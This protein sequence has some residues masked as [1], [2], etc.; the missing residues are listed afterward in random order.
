ME[1]RFFFFFF[2]FQVFAKVKKSKKHKEVVQLECS[3]K[4]SVVM[5]LLEDI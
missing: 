4:H 5:E 3:T 1:T 2:V